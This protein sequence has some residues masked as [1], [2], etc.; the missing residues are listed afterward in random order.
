MSLNDAL[1]LAL[2]KQ[3]YLSEVIIFQDL[4]TDDLAM[5]RPR[6]TKSRSF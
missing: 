3:S 4:S 1:A 2:R 6:L 5:G